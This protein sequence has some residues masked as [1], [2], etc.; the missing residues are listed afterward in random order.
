M[1]MLADLLK[2]IIM[3]ERGPGNW[4]RKN[5]LMM[6]LPPME[7]EK[8]G[9]VMEP[10][11]MQI[12]MQKPPPGTISN[13]SGELVDFNPDSN[14]FKKIIDSLPGGGQGTMTGMLKMLFGSDMKK[15][16]PGLSRG[17]TFVSE[18]LSPV[19]SRKQKNSNFRGTKTDWAPQPD[20]P[21]DY[22][23]PTALDPQSLDELRTSLLTQ[24]GMLDPGNPNSLPAR[25]ANPNAAAMMKSQVDEMND[26]TDAVRGPIEEDRIQRMKGNR[27]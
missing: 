1:A 9:Q 20:L 3:G 19:P 15:E 2:N 25:M 8:S 24:S 12:Q 17:S 26:I 18:D 11:R 23:Q 6:E 27:R 10:D 21:P 22:S 14:P 16:S 4:P 13:D 7:G 5:D